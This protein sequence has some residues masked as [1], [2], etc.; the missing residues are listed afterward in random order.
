MK[1]A[2]A[3]F[4]G[5]AA[6]FVGLFIDAYVIRNTDMFSLPLTLFLAVLT[7]LGYYMYKGFVEGSRFATPSLFTESHRLTRFA[8]PPRVIDDGKMDWA[9]LKVGGWEYVKAF[10][11]QKNFTTNR[12]PV[13]VM[14]AQL[15]EQTGGS[16]FLIGE[17]QLVEAEEEAIRLLYEGHIEFRRLF[18]SF[19][20][21]PT[22]LYFGYG[23]RTA[24]ED[25]EHFIRA[26]IPHI[27]GQYQMTAEE[28]GRKVREQAK[29]LNEDLT[30]LD[31]AQAK[32]D[33]SRKLTQAFDTRQGE[34]QG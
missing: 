16:R 2:V 17:V 31:R 21:V 25:A 26:D 9:V 6:P 14:P 15:L 5:F 4:I 13:V 27:A 30:K 8:E 29:K 11:H 18:D 3:V 20:S 34:E 23:S 28:F 22:K 1:R 32:K 19:E 24:H 33:I 12:G 10:L 7:G